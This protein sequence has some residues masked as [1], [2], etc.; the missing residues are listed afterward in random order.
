MVVTENRKCCCWYWRVFLFDF[1]FLAS[2]LVV[3]AAECGELVLSFLD[4]T[5]L[6]DPIQKLEVVINIMAGIILQAQFVGLLDS[7]KMRPLLFAN[8]EKR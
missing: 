6:K 4:S 8:P 7:T 1:T 5:Y 3:K 2:K